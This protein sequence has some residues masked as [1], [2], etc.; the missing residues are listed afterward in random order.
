MYPGDE[1]LVLVRDMHS[2]HSMGTAGPDGAKRIMAVFASAG[3]RSTRQR[4]LIAEHLAAR[5]TNASDF[6]TEDLWKEL[7]TDDPNL[8]RATVY[9][10]IE[11]LYRVGMLDRVTF[12][13]GAHRYRLCGTEHHHHVTCVRCR[14]VVEVDVCL[15]PG[16]LS[17]VAATTDF[18][19]EGHAL[20]LFG[21]CSTCQAGAVS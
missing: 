6:A 19:I 5:G 13:D 14:R 17:T 3:L 15:P 12:A 8:G 1:E 20:D 9:R 10:A 7:Q 4:R 11:L 21:L 18:T 16:L 2:H